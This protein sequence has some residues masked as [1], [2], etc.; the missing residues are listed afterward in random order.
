VPFCKRQSTPLPLS[1]SLF[2]SL[3]LKYVFNCSLIPDIIIF[4]HTVRVHK[5]PM[6]ILK[7]KAFAFMLYKLPCDAFILCFYILLIHFFC[8][9]CFE[10]IK[11][12]VMF[13]QYGS[14]HT[15]NVHVHLHVFYSSINHEAS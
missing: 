8:V 9:F 15:T 14:K 10:E 4:S 7:A 3:S 12:K 2:L 13:L 11:K 6:M 5:A 1:L